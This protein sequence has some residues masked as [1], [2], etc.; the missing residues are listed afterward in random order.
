MPGTARV[1]REGVPTLGFSLC[2][3]SCL[4]LCRPVGTPLR[5]AWV[6]SGPH[7]DRST[8][9]D[10]LHALHSCLADFTGGYRLALGVRPARGGLFLRKTGTPQQACSAAPSTGRHLHRRSRQ[11]ACSPASVSRLFLRCLSLGLS[12]LLLVWLDC[13]GIVS[14]VLFSFLN[15]KSKSFHFADLYFL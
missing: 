15:S 13:N 12:L 6:P 9:F 14:S 2:L 3:R 10:H 5:E 4:C 11:R 8:R 1:T 7:L